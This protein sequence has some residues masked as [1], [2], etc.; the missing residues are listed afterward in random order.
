MQK[1]YT[2]LAELARVIASRKPIDQLLQDACEHITAHTGAA[3]TYVSSIDQAMATATVVAVDGECRKFIRAKPISL[4]PDEAEGMGLTA[5]IWR[6][7]RPLIFN[8]LETSPEL[9]QNKRIFASFGLASAAGIPLKSKGQCRAVLV[10]VSNERW[11]FTPRLVSLVDRMG[12]MLSVA[13]EVA[14]EADLGRRYLGFY[15]ALAEL[16]DLVTRKVEPKM[17]FE[18]TCRLIT[19]LS[20]NLAAAIVAR[21]KEGGDYRFE[22]W[23]SNLADQAITRDLGSMSFSPEP[24]S[25]DGEGL[26]REVLRG[27]KSVYWDEHVIAASERAG[28]KQ[29][30]NAGS[31]SLLGIPILAGDECEGVFLLSATGA[32]YFT[33]EIQ[34][35]AERIAGNLGQAILS[36]RQRAELER[37][38]LTDTLTG[39][40]NRAL[41]MDRLGMAIAQAGRD[42]KRVALAVID[43]D[44]LKEINDQFGHLSG[45]ETLRTVA[46]NMV[47]QVRSADTVA[48]LGGDEFAAI[49]HIDETD[50]ALHAIAQRLME[51]LTDSVQIGGERVSISASIGFALYPDDATNAEDLLRRAD[52]AMYRGKRQGGKSWHLFEAEAEEQLINRLQLKNRFETALANGQIAFHYQ[53]KVDMRTGE[54]FGAE[55]LARWIDPQNGVLSPGAWISAVETDASLSSALGRYALASV[56]DQLAE[57]HAKGLKIL[58]SLNVG[59][60]H[61]QMPW[62]LDDVSRALEKAPELARYLGLEVTETALVED[63]DRVRETLRAC[64]KLGIRIALDDFGTGYA[65]LWYLQNLPADVIKVDLEFIQKMPMDM[66]A[67]SIVAGTLQISQMSGIDVVAEGVET[68]EHGR[69]LLQLGCHRAQG[70]AISRPLPAGDFEKWVKTWQLPVSWQNERLVKIVPARHRLLGSLVYHRSRRTLMSGG[71]Q[72]VQA[73][74]LLHDHCPLDSHSEPFESKVLEQLYALHWELHRLEDAVIEGFIGGQ[75]ASKSDEDKL[76]TCLSDYER[77]IDLALAGKDDLLVR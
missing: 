32:H 3:V 69:R 37:Q 67:F 54:I 7:G 26:I 64:R 73:Q 17:L 36:F 23:K 27:K 63:F 50:E 42:G 76:V 57:W 39:I 2:A 71:T 6:A 9:A 20:S 8:D 49:F 40:P 55:A 11:H 46:R 33:E 51:A 1:Y 15:A 58:I 31:R 4:M 62:F 25:G 61:L 34:Q 19:R 24:E 43:I 35:L 74:E 21:G 28:I 48:R 18:E 47:E 60:R 66:R 65:S 70:Y 52:I 22:A 38:A 13:V 59:A 16:N 12:D 5:Q 68:E 56:I 53:P 10:L 75:T 29:L 30:W 77:L 14:D 41:L 72:Q 44:G 45:D